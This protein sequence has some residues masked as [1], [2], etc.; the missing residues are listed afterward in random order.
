MDEHVIRNYVRH[1]EV[2]VSG[3]G[4][5]LRDEAGHQWI[6]ML[7]GIAVSALGHGHPRLVAALR[8]QVGKVLHVSNLYRHP[9]TEDVAARLARLTGL[10][11]VYFCNSG[12]EAN[13][14]AIKL[15]RKHQRMRGKPEQVGLVAVEGG[16]HG[17]TLG[18][19]SLTANPAY[20]EPFGPLI[21]S[22]RYVP[23]D[24]VG[25][26]EA[27]FADAPAAFV[28]EPIQGEAGIVELDRGFLA[29]ARE[30]C[31]ETGALFVADEVQTGCGR[32]GTFLRSQALD[33]TPDVVTLAKPL[34]AGVPVGAMVVRE[35]LAS[36]LVPGDHGS[37]FAG[38][39]LAL[40]AAQVLLDELENGLQERVV[41]AGQ[42]LG[43]RLARM[44]AR[45]AGIVQDVRGHG[46][47]RAL[48]LPDHAAAVQKALH[49]RRVITNSTGD[50]V[51]FL[52]A[53]VITHAETDRAMDALEDVLDELS[54]AAPAASSQ[55][56]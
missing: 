51:R 27:A 12:A 47:M 15:A 26:L 35:S 25:A 29:R 14:A 50:A 17:R 6:D 56:T 38:G 39:P 4:A 42:H 21:P 2:F 16:F 54:T 41:E 10:D 20:R 45:F 46:L 40:C 43:Q 32:T 37:T 44:A 33:L 1:P 5:V 3:E 11:A 30:L 19:L 24:D 55:N 28:V 7:G 31:R 34:A 52:P 22:V 36:V 49:A 23:R 9:F 13:E 53:F 48:H 8:E 18:A